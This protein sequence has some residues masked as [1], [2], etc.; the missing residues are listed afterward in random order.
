MRVLVTGAQGCIGAWVVKQL[1]GRGADVLVYDRDAST[2]RLAMIASPAE[3]AKVKFEQGQIEDGARIKALVKDG[4][5][6]HIIHL[7]AVL[8]PYC[9]ANPVAG[10]MIN[11]IGT[12]NVFEAAR[13]AGRPV[14]ISYASSSAVWGPE[15]AYEARKLNEE[16][17]LHP[18]THYGVFKQANEGNARIFYTASGISSV[19]LRPWTVYGVGRDAGLTA[20]PSLAMRAVANGEPFRI[21]VTG[22]MDLQYV[23]DVAEMFIRGAISELEGAHVF[24]LAGEVIRME[25]LITLLDRIRPG[26]AKLVTCAGPTVGVAYRMDDSAIRAK[27]PDLPRTPLEVGAARTIENFEKLRA[28]G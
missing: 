27:L 23:E 9:Q 28:A 22:F 2:A 10:G 25:E 12:L 19:G 16:D 20:G 6:T 11:V 8:M 21:A 24:N 26:A 18:G 3:I 4:G 1:I 15:E 17:P 14:R 7:A 5:I 13:D